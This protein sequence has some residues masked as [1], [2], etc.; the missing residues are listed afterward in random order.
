[1]GEYGRERWL[2]AQ[3]LSRSSPMLALSESDWASAS[4]LSAYSLVATT[5]ALAPMLSAGVAPERPEMPD[6]EWERFHR[7]QR[8]ASDEEVNT[9]H[10]SEGPLPTPGSAAESRLLPSHSSVV[11]LTFEGSTRVCPPYGVMGPSKAAL[12]AASRALA[13]ELGPLGV[14]SNC[15]SPGP[16]NTLAARG[17]PG[18]TELRE[19]AQR[20]SMR[21]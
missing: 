21:P 8:G 3:R 2:E 4:S 14:T 12:E 9:C 15:V 17:I 11:A 5:R 18:F 20:S 13:H 1:M 7:S 10:T 19:R 6:P 16:V